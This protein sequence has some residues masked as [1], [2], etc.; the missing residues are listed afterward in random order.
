MIR[1][2]SQHLPIRKILLLF[3]SL[4]P[5]LL[6]SGCQPTQVLDETTLITGMGFD[7]LDDKLIRATV[8]APVVSSM[9][10]QNDQ[11]VSVTGTTLYGIMNSLDLQLDRRPRLGQLRIVLFSEEMARKGIYPITGALNL[12]EVGIRPY[13]GI[14]DGKAYDLVNASYPAQ[15]NIGI[16]LYNIIYKN[17]RGEQLPSPT[18]HEFMRDYYGTGSDPFLP[19]IE[20]LGNGIKVKGVALLKND[21]FVGWVNPHKTFY[22]KLMRDQFR[23]GL[24]QLTIPTKDL[25]S[26]HPNEMEESTPIVLDTLRSRQTV[27]LI[28]A[29]PPTFDVYVEVHA[30]LAEMREK[31]NLESKKVIRTIERE[32]ENKMEKEMADLLKT[33]QKM[34][35]DPIGFGETYRSQS[36]FREMEKEEWRKLYRQAKFTFRVNMDIIRLSITN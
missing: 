28:S 8:T 26:V 3:L 34:D 33:L 20:R 1:G 6:I 35:V 27:K 19:Y 2:N 12:V 18:L 7:L 23:A 25:E 21:R 29:N 15:G 10:Q 30:R 5:V 11:V 36:H 32:V 16:Y 22:I 9:V 4:L 17:V 24:F 14:V 13:I 31:V